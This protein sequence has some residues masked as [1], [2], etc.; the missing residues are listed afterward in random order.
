MRRD[1]HKVDLLVDKL[2]VKDVAKPATTWLVPHV[3]QMAAHEGLKHAEHRCPGCAH[4]LPTPYMLHLHAQGK[5]AKAAPNKL[6]GP[7][8]AHLLFAPL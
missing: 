3:P 2:Q 1:Q 6:Q 7:D 4:C 5:Q 8:L